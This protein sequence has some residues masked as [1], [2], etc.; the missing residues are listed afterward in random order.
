MKKISI[1]ALIILT[2]AVSSWALEVD[3]DEILKSERVNFTNYSGGQ[4]GTDSVSAIQDIG[5][6]LARGAKTTRY[7]ELFKYHMKY[8]IL[9]AMSDEDDGKYSADIFFIDQGAKV[10]H[11]KNVRRII[12]S[13]LV[14]MYK[15]STR[16]ADT[17]ALFLSYYNAIYRGDMDY[18][19]KTYN[20]AVMKHVNSSNAG[21]AT[22]YLEWPGKTAMLI[23]LTSDSK[24]DKLKGIDPF[25]VADKKTIGEVKKEKSNLDAR[26][27]MTDL[28]QKNI[29]DEKARIEKEKKKIEEEKAS[30]Q[31]KE[32]KIRDE[33]KKTEEA[34]KALAKEQEQLKKEKAKAET[35]Q[36]QKKREEEKKKLSDKEN[37]LK[38]KADALK[39]QE[40]KQE[41]EMTSIEKDK[42]STGKQEESLKKDEKVI[43]EKEKILK[44]EKKELSEDLKKEKQ[45]TK[46][47]TSDEVQKKRK[48]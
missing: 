28:K 26:K 1:I 47:L 15:Y 40:A 23:P 22:N 10:D 43:A 3:V 36:D 14:V 31:A 25:V 42:S 4:R 11:I 9:R 44:E 16:E 13:Y 29:A 17:L 46:K 19:S 34:K 18:L 33:Q 35:I 8:S 24:R 32:K 37:E 21:I 41:E 45:E 5:M 12:S 38:R 30:R 27:E 20:K 39:K 7:N 6:Q 2:S 48:N